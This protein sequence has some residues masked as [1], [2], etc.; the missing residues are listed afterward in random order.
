MIIKLSELQSVA[1]KWFDAFNDHDL[2]RLL[3]LYD[4]N[5]RHYSPKLKIRH[6]E[7]KGL[8]HGKNALREWWQDAFNRLPT[9]NYELIRLT[10]YENRVFMEYV[11]HVHGEEDL[12]V[13]EM[14]EVEN[15]KIVASSV[16]HR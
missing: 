10:P 3:S 16:F 9:L 8:I 11:R 2:E 13:G 1:N 4:E 15:E 14:L 5:A 6:P 7:S 12:Y